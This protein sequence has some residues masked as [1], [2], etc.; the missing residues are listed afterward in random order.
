MKTFIVS[1][2]LTSAVAIIGTNI[3]LAADASPAGKSLGQYQAIV[4]R[5]PF[6][7]PAEVI[8][9]PP[10]QVWVND[11]TVVGVATSPLTGALVAVIEE[12]AS[13]Q[14]F[15]C[16]PG[17]AVRGDILVDRLEA[18]GDK[19][20]VHLKKGTQVATLQFEAKTASDVAV[21]SAPPPPG[22][23]GAPGAP[24]T[25]TARPPVPIRRP[26]TPIR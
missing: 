7:P 10:Q 5:N 6:C 24:G 4:Q 18:A 16:G 12:K 8:K 1:A 26:P 21:K 13:K 23:P 2:L 14:V 17:E 20:Q 25:P 15:Y 22:A 11:F 9:D 3:G 19:V